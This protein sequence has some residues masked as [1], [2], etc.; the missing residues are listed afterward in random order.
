MLCFQLRLL[1]IA[2][3][4]LIA[5]RVFAADLYVI[6]NDAV[7]MTREDL[8]EVF[9]G[10]AQFFGSIKLQPIDN[11]GAQA[12]FLATVLKM[13]G[14]KYVAS[15]TKKAFR[16]GLNAPPLKATDADVLL[17]VKNNPGAIGYVTSAPQGV[18]VVGKF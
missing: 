9:L 10:E 1:A 12:E 2:V 5:D 13:T 11:A 15:W 17:F 3:L 4:L 16:D 18:H 6:S 14:P 8:K 7:A